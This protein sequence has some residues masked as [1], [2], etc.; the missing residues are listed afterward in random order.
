[1][2]PLPP[3][4]SP[5]LRLTSATA[6][7]ALE[8]TQA[9][10]QVVVG[11]ATEVEGLRVPRFLNGVTNAGVGQVQYTK[12]AIIHLGDRLDAVERLSVLGR[13][14][15]QASQLW[16]RVGQVVAVGIDNGGLHILALAVEEDEIGTHPAPLVLNVLVDDR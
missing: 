11:G 3:S 9:N 6:T 5:R 13:E 10:L 1:M 15:R 8:S 12:H 7:R 16:K 14:P 2:V 4:R